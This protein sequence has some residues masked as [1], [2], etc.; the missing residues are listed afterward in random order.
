MLD[1]AAQSGRHALS[2]RGRDLYETPP[3]AT[4]ALLCAE[5]MPL[6]IWEPCAGKGAIVGVLRDHGHE[7]I[8]S[9]IVEYGFPL[10]FVG[11][12]LTTTK[13]PAGCEAIATNPPYRY[14][15]EFARHALDLVPRVYLLLRLAFL[16]SECRADILE[17]RGLACVHVF[18]KRLPFMHRDNWAGPRASSATAFSWYV[19][20]RDH[21]GP[22]IVDRISWERCR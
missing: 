10:D 14:A 13:V 12:F 18:R 2:E 4:E 5:I 8:A 15:A 17:R 20:D 1:H 3:C 6:R 9:D 19:W 16:E 22:T 7:V 11:D 21:R